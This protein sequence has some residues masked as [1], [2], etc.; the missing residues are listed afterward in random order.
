MKTAC[1]PAIITKRTRSH[2]MLEIITGYGQKRANKNKDI[3]QTNMS[4]VLY[5][6]ALKNDFLLETDATEEQILLSEFI[7]CNSNDFDPDVEELPF[8][9][10]EE[11]CNLQPGEFMFTDW[12]TKVTRVAEGGEV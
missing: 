3:K 5:E 7:K 9:E 10:L 12:G 4:K 6:R 8:D 2:R 11:I 1:T